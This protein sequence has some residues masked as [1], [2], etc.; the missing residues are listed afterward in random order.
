MKV[1]K[2]REFKKVLSRADAPV[3]KM[4]KRHAGF[5]NNSKRIRKNYVID[6]ETAQ[7]MDDLKHYTTRKLN[8]NL[9]HTEIFQIA[10]RGLAKRPS[11]LAKWIKS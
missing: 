6:I 11:L 3:I 9:S 5:L 1:R 7:C 10:M 8:L 4:S 2:K